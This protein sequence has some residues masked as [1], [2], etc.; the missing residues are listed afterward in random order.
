MPRHQ[1]IIVHPTTTTELST[2]TASEPFN[3]NPSTLSFTEE[4]RRLRSPLLTDQNWKK[5]RSRRQAAPQQRSFEQKV[6]SQKF[7]L[8]EEGTI[9]RKKNG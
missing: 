7:I 3:V 6:L 2:T 5:T 1:N 4:F 8:A 9:F